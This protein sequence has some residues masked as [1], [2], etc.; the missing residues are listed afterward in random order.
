MDVNPEALYI[1][2]APSVESC[3]FHNSG[4]APLN[5]L[6]SSLHPGS[7]LVWDVRDFEK[8][9]GTT[10]NSDQECKGA[11]VT[12]ISLAISRGGAKI[13]NHPFSDA[14]R[15]AMA[16]GFMRL[17]KALCCLTPQE[18]ILGVRKQGIQARELRF[19]C[20]YLPAQE[21]P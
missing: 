4:E 12:D 9:E 10:S 14:H 15:F 5:F 3:H 16:G 18:I 1:I 17:P 8:S 2:I 19:V 7:D 21:P 11:T 6:C 20:E 13:N